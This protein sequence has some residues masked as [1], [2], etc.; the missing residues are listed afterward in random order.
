MVDAAAEEHSY[1]AVA[2]EGFAGASVVACFGA[3]AAAACSEDV[4]AA[5]CLEGAARV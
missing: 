1:E 3:E 5:E 2:A 4:P